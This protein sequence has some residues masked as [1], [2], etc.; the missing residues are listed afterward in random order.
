MGVEKRN[1]WVMRVW[2]VTTGGVGKNISMETTGME[3]NV[4]T[5][6]SVKQAGER[7]LR[8]TLMSNDFVN[9]NF[10]L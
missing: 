5:N 2:V 6:L 7:N 8:I 4:G 9:L 3:P 10:K 1:S